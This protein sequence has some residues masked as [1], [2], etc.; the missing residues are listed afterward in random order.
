M[1]LWSFDKN[2]KTAEMSAV[3]RKRQH[4][5]LLEKDKRELGFVVRG[6]VVEPRNI[7]RWMKR[8][9]IDPDVVYA[10][11]SVASE[12]RYSSAGSNTS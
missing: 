4:R 11:P 5:N 10:P 3:V 9:R 8:R 7:D 12:D 1:T 6:R 2:I